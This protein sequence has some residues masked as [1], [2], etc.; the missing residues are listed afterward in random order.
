[1]NKLV[2]VLVVLVL[3]GLCIGGG[4]V[5]GSKTTEATSDRAIEDIRDR[6]LREAARKATTQSVPRADWPCRATAN[7]GKTTWT[8][9]YGTLETCTLPITA[10]EKA[11]VGCPTKLRI[12]VVGEDGKTTT[13]ETAFRYEAGRLV[14]E[15]I[16]WKDG[17]AVAW[18]NDEF[19]Y[20][21][22]GVSTL[23]ETAQSA[24]SIRDGRLQE[25]TLRSRGSSPIQLSITTTLT[26]Q[27][28]RLTS[29]SHLFTSMPEASVLTLEYGCVR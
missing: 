20:A 10:H 14:D 18:D 2:V 26:W 1:M 9:E 25:V 13:N 12:D 27:G 5:G 4:I 11:I 15:K 21:G 22:D 28:T 7:A 29:L 16:T 19:L 8:F 17:L 23:S 6:N 3:A 24:W